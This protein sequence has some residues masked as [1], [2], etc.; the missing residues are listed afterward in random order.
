M[1]QKQKNYSLEDNLR[2]TQH[3]A[4]VNQVFLKLLAKQKMSS[5]P[6]DKVRTETWNPSGEIKQGVDSSDTN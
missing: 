6:F 1:K 5:N 3:N 2:D 4:K